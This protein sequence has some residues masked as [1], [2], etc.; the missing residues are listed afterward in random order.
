M[1]DMAELVIRC[2]NNIQRTKFDRNGDK[3]GNFVLKVGNLQFSWV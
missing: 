2:P 1:P 3:S